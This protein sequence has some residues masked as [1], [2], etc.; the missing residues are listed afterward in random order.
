[1]SPSVE[2][3][4]EVPISWFAARVKCNHLCKAPSIESGTSQRHNKKATIIIYSGNG[5]LLFL[6]LGAAIISKPCF[7]GWTGWSWSQGSP[8]GS[9]LIG[10]WNLFLGW[11]FRVTIK[12]QAW[13]L[14][15]AL[16][17]GSEPT[18]EE[19][20]DDSTMTIVP[21]GPGLS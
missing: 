5:P 10:R 3:S 20:E 11:L 12:T 15:T 13:V 17:F 7:L 21:I 2:S 1:M 14:R 4:W 16:G 18:Y 6:S 8:S 9:L 19:G